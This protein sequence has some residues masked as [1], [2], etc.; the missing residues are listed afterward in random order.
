VLAAGTSDLPARTAA[1]A[2]PVLLD[3]ARRLDPPRLRRV[4]GHLRYVTDPDG[5]EQQQQR[6]YARRGVVAVA[7]GGVVVT[8]ASPHAPLATRRPG[9][10]GGAAS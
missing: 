2:Q 1:E 3:A 4:I 8:A 10:R 9:W 6:R 5:A 7:D